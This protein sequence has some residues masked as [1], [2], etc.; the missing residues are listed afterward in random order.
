MD[1]HWQNKLRTV[2]SQPIDWRRSTN[3][4]CQ[5]SVVCFPVRVPPPSS[6]ACPDL[7]NCR[8]KGQ[9]GYTRSSTTASASLR[10]ATPKACVCSP[11][12]ATISRRASRR[13]STR[14]RVCVAPLPAALGYRRAQPQLF[15]RPRQQRS[16]V[17]LRV[18]RD[19]P[20]RRTAANL[21]TR[22]E[23]R[24]IAANIAKLPELLRSDK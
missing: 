21:L 7:P 14:S 24:R 2:S 22:D 19:E 23:A 10:G 1:V 9:A 13:S 15:H 17:G 11:A 20:G 5:T 3:R 12:M 8:Q 16:G 18:F 6:P 4:K